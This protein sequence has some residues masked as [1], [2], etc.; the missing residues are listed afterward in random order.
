MRGDKGEIVPPARRWNKA[1][2]ANLRR[3]AIEEDELA[4][5]SENHPVFSR[6]K[7]AVEK[8]KRARRKAADLR[9]EADRLDPR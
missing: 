7:G 8:A 9:A 2:A 1:K 4:D 5:V 6:M 3:W